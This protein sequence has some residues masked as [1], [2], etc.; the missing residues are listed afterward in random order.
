[1]WL[2]CTWMNIYKFSSLIKINV[3]KSCVFTEMD[4]KPNRMQDMPQINQIQTNRQN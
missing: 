2:F 4:A 1:M 3:F